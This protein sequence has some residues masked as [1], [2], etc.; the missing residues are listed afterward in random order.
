MDPREAPGI[1]GDPPDPHE[2]ML[3]RVCDPNMKDS[4]KWQGQGDADVREEEGEEGEDE[5]EEEGEE[6]EEEEEEE[7]DVSADSSHGESQ[8]DD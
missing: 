7:D 1:S 6:G 5:E 8:E 4:E 3:A 2:P